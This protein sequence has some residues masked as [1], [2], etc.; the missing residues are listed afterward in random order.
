MV[1]D[2]T[3]LVKDNERLRDENENL[4]RE[5]K[6]LSNKVISLGEIIKKKEHLWSY[7]ESRFVKVCKTCNNEEKAKCLMFPEYCEGEC[8]E[9]VDLVSLLEKAIEK[10]GVQ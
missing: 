10:G 1:T 8:S 3:D 4:K 2:N 5:I 7:L 9:F 6:S